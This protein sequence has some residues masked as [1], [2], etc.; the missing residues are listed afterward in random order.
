MIKE[1]KSY[2][3]RTFDCFS[4]TLTWEEIAVRHPKK[5]FIDPLRLD[6]SQPQNCWIQ[7]SPNKR[8]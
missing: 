7:T 8:T 6:F 3:A 1:E 4:L 5:A 2:E